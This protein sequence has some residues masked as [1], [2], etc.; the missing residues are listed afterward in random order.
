MALRSNH[1]VSYKSSPSLDLV[2]RGRS[3][4]GGGRVAKS[5]TKSKT[6]KNKVKKKTNKKTTAKQK[7]SS[8]TGGKKAGGTRTQGKNTG[9]KKKGGKNVKSHASSSATSTLSGYCPLETNTKSS[10]TSKSSKASKKHVGPRKVGAKSGAKAGGKSRSKSNAKS[11][12]ICNWR[13]VLRPVTGDTCDYLVSCELSNEFD[14]IGPDTYIKSSKPTAS[15]S[16]STKT[17]SRTKSSKNRAS[18]LTGRG[19]RQVFSVDLG[20]AKELDVRGEPRRYKTT[21]ER[22]EKLVIYSLD[23]PSNSDLYEGDG[24]SL[25]P[26][27]IDWTSE[28]KL[29]TGEA[30]ALKDVTVKDLGKKPKD[31]SRYVTEHLIEVQV[32][33]HASTILEGYC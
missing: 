26:V 18:K 14:S 24:A 22:A 6:T 8:K 32:S 30:T 9:S 17:S 27:T 7:G 25:K 12:D 2:A 3:K 1:D 13:P 5:P 15:K 29:A 31:Y 16:K 21:I 4:K 33:L 28:K 20:N 19:E 11:D 23:Y 10:K